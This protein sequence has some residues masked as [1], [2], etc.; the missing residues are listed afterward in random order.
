MQPR[1]KYLQADRNAMYVFVQV[2]VSGFTG[3]DTVQSV[4]FKQFGPVYAS[5]VKDLMDDCLGKLTKDI[6]ELLYEI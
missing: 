3:C 1:K 2:W 6:Y 4:P 5:Q